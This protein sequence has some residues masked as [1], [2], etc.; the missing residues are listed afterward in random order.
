[1]LKRRAAESGASAF[2]PPLPEWKRKAI[3][4]GQMCVLNKLILRF[5][6]C[7]W[8]ADQYAFAY[9]NRFPNVHGSMIIN[10][11]PSNQIPALV[12]ML[13][14]D[15]GRS[16][17][18]RSEHDNLIWGMQHVRRL[19]GV[20]V[21]DPLEVI[22]TA[23]EQDPFTRGSFTNPTLAT[24]HGDNA[25]LARS[26]NHTL[27]FAGE[28]TSVPYYATVHGALLSGLEAAMRIAGSTHCKLLQDA[29][30]RQTTRASL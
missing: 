27:H 3:D 21:P 30:Q 6:K 7:Y 25:L 16:F 22:I 26:V 1:V 19:F 24:Q 8:P 9:V 20:D 23:W 4:R 28:H 12:M 18:R 11:M 10:M 14:G 5:D 17:E 2:D 13:G 29:V 15:Q